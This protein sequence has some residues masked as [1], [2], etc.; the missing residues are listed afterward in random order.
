MILLVYLNDLWSYSIKDGVWT[1]VSGN[2]DT[3][4]Y[5]VYGNKGVPNKNNIPGSRGISTSWMDN[6]NNLFL[7]GGSGYG[8]INEQGIL[9]YIYFND[10]LLF[11]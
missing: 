5:G 8:S 4:Q 9:I 2:N 6:E 7:Y 11:I 10:Y 3:Y 1:W